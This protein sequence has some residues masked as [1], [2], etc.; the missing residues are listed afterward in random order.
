[1]TQGQKATPELLAPAGDWAS[2]RAA[3]EAGADSVYFGVKGIN[4]RHLAGNFDRLELPKVMA[5]LREKG[6]KGYLTLNTV[7]REPDLFKARTILEAARSAGVNA[8]ILWDMAV[9][10]LAKQM[11]LAIHLSTQASVANVE[12]L[13]WYADL[14]ARRVV[15]A[16]ECTL[17]DIRDIVR[18]RDQRQIPCSIE[19]FAHGA[20]C[21]SISGRCFLSQYSFDQSANQGKCLQP[22]RRKFQIKD[23]DGQAEYVLGEDYVLSPRDLCTIEFL[24][25][26]VASGADSLKIEGRM[27]APEYI[28]AVTACYRKALT[29]LGQGRLDNRQKAVLTKELKTVYN[30]G[31]SSGFYFGRPAEPVSQG[32]EHEYEK[33]YLG[34]VTRFFKNI[35]VAEIRLQAGDLRRGEQLLFIGK[36]TPAH[37]AMAEEIQQEHRSVDHAPKGAAVGVKLPFTARPKDKV[38]LWRKK[39]R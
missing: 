27:R 35:R 23:L 6:L 8:I 22:C 36:S 37:M 11:G 17:K 2:L 31:F 4:M 25:E 10:R 14:G 16:R 9:F 15:L 33:I 1:M 28:R 13:Q 26:V 24:D 7:I 18:F 12:A 20:M 29:L 38:F 5:L 34:Q 3:I 39:Q 21:V 32:L 19:V 30:R